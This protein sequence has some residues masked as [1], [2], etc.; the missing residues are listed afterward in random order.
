M[1][2]LIKHNSQETAAR[3]D[4]FPYNH[5]HYTSMLTW[6]ETNAKKGQRLVTRTYNPFTKSWPKPKE[7]PFHDLVFL[8]RNPY[9]G[10]TQEQQINLYTLTNEEIL[11]IVSNYY[12]TPEQKATLQNHLSRVPNAIYT[13]WSKH[14]VAE[15]AQF[16]EVVPVREPISEILLSYPHPN[17]LIPLP[18]AV[19]PAK[20]VGRPPVNRESMTFSDIQKKRNNLHDKEA[21]ELAPE[22]RDFYY[23]VVGKTN[24]DRLTDAQVEALQ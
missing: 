11:Y 22:R 2:Q 14:E 3:F 4:F 9:T 10:F 20:P 17:N 24:P 18:A 23:N 12:V 19:T 1:H 21:L 15:N 16:V 5:G 8:F 6:V 13:M 7:F